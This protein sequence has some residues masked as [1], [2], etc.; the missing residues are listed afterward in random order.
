[1][2]PESRS[3]K[4]RC[5]SVLLEVFGEA[6][7]GDPSGLIQAWHALPDFHVDPT[8]FRKLPEVV[9]GHNLV[10]DETERDAHVFVPRHRIVVVI[11]LDV[12]GEKTSLRG[13]Y[14][15]V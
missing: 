7:V 14:D 8:M 9:L 11:I 13:R 5:V 15:A 4:A 1:M 3:T 6:F 2:T 12:E 10:W